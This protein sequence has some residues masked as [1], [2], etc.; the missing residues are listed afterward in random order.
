M[1]INKQNKIIQRTHLIHLFNDSVRWA[2]GT[3]NSMKTCIIFAV[4]LFQI[5]TLEINL[6]KFLLVDVDGPEVKNNI[7][8]SRGL[9]WMPSADEP[10]KEP[11]EGCAWDAQCCQGFTCKG[12]PLIGAIF[13]KK[14]SCKRDPMQDL[15]Q[16]YE[17]KECLTAD[18]TK[19]IIRQ[20]CP[21]TCSDENQGVDKKQC[22]MVDCK[23]P[24]AKRVCP[25]TCQN[26]GIGSE[27]INDHEFCNLV[28]CNDPDAAEMCPD[29]C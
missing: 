11:D 13:G 12:M 27:G 29:T 19:P 18:C 10:C 22:K 20:T 3:S 14:R 5:V 1:G 4:Q 21:K 25:N 15:P 17:Q 2:F 9:A 8:M 28:D 26:E 6:A 16:W 23:K 24:G 7:A